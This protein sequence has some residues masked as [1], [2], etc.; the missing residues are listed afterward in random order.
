VRPIS[1]SRALALISLALLLAV[2]CAVGCGSSRQQNAFGIGGS[3]SSDNGPTGASGDDGVGGGSG[4]SSSSGGSGEVFTSNSTG[5]AP[6]CQSGAGW[7]CSVN[8][9]CGSAP[10]T[11][12]GKA[13]D[14]AGINPLANVVVFIPNDATK[15]P[16]ITPGTHS[17][18]TCDTPIGDYVV[19]TL[20]DA[21]GSF[22]LKGVPTGKGVPVVVQIGKWRRIMSVDTKDCATTT[23]AKGAL[24]LPR[25][26]SEGSMPQMALLTGGFDNLGC[27]PGALGIDPKEYSAPHAG[28]RLDIYQGLNSPLGATIGN[29]PG[30]SSGTAGNCTTSSCPLWSTKPNL[31][32]YDI[33]MLS[34]EG[35]EANQTK[36]TA[37]MQAMHD[38][39]NEGGKV[40]ATH[41]QYTWFKNN[42]NTDFQS[43]AT[44][45]GPSI[46]F[47]T[48]NYAIDTSFTKGMMFHD[49]L[50][51]VGALTN[52]TIALTGVGTSV[53]TVNPPTNQWIYDTKTTPTNAKYLSFGTPVGGAPIVDAGSEVMGKQYCGK[54]VFTDLHA[55][56]APAGD[57]PAAC[58]GD[59]LTPQ[60]DA[61]E[62]LFFDLAA[63][64]HDDSLPPPPPPPPAK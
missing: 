10:T 21:T 29:G 24:R 56:G 9:S 63:C 48:G 2:A 44:W 49:W 58:K 23:V 11:L 13:Y 45:L 54:A 47:A 55:G 20:T 33:V 60:L 17:C 6:T 26:Q 32:S 27:F 14:P 50:V 34:C 8:T 3:A 31:E 37:A 43:V 5:P 28:G 30:L 46:A 19:A 39:L 7:S 64:V 42:P 61:L 18:N 41:Y 40:F 22:T 16:A 15:L 53:S 51:M 62:Y 4:G 25:N 59:T 12:T 57:V 38:W 52:G 36:P 1:L 35:D